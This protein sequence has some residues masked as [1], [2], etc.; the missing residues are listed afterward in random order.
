MDIKELQ[1][2]RLS[3]AVKFHDS[4]N[5]V[6]WDNNEH[7]RPEV[8]AALLKIAE[9]FKEFLGVSDFDL[10]DIT[11]S[12]SNAA[13]SY[14][15]HSDVDL[16]L[17]VDLPKADLSDVYR[18]LFD[19]KKYQYNDQ[20]NY[21]IGDADV[22][23]YVQNANQPHVSQGIYSIL[24]NDWLRVPNKRQPEIHDISVRSKYQ[25]LGHRIEA[26]IASKD[27]AQMAAIADKVKQLRKSGLA[28]TGEFGP[29]NLAFKLLRNNGLL[30]AL[31]Q[32]RRA[33]KDREFSI[34][35]RK[36]RRTKWGQ[37]GGLWFPGFDMYGSTNGD[38]AEGSESQQSVKESVEP[39]IDK[40][41][42]KPILR[43][44][45]DS[46]VKY[47]KLDHAP[48]LVVKTDPAWQ[49]RNGSFGRFDHDTNTI[50]LAT[51]N[52]HILDILRTMAH[53]ITHARQNE[54][55]GNMPVD[56]GVTGSPFEDHA[57]A[58]A[59]RIMR[60][61]ADS[62]PEYF[63]GI[64]LTAEDYD[65]NGPPPGPEFKPTMPAGTVKVDV[66]DVY[67]WYKLG[68]HV[69]NLKGLG[70]HDFGKGPPSTIM[71]FGSEQEEHKYIQDLEK[72]GL[73]T[74]DI[75]PVDP[76]QPPG[77]KRQKTDPTYNVN[78]A[79]G[80]IP[81]NDKEAK[82]PRYSMAITQDIK[83]GE[84]KRQAAKMG[85][86]TSIAGLPPIAKTNG[87][88]EAIDVSRYQPG[89]LIDLTNN[90]S[91]YTALVG[92]IDSVSP[93]NMVKMT[94]VA[95]DPKPG[96]KA[97]LTTGTKLNIHANYLKRSPVS[98][99]T[100]AEIDRR[101][102]LKGITGTAAG[103][104]GLLG[105]P[106]DVAQAR[107]PQVKRPASPREWLEYIAKASGIVGDEFKA[108]L[109]QVAHETLNF[110]KMEE[111][112][113]ARYFQKKYDIT[114]NPAKAKKLGNTKPGDG[115]RY[116]G[117]GLIQLT[118]KDNYQKAG[119]YLYKKGVLKSP[120]ELV[121][122]PALA[123]QPDLAARIAIWY[124]QKRVAPKVQ[125]FTNVQATTKPINPGMKHLKQRQEKFRQ[126]QAGTLEEL[127]QRLAEGLNEFKQVIAEVK[128]SPIEYRKWLKSPEAQG[129]MAGFEAELIF[130]DAQGGALKDEDDDE[131]ELQA[132]YSNNPRTRSISNIVDFYENDDWG[133]GLSPRRR[134]RLIEDLNEAWIEW[135]DE[136]L[137][138]QWSGE[139]NDY[140]RTWILENIDE[141]E[142]LAALGMSTA[143]DRDAEV[144]NAKLDELVDNELLNDGEYATQARQ[145]FNDEYRDDY[146]ESTWLDENY[147]YMDD[148]EGGF[149]VDW[150][151]LQD[152][153]GG[154][155]DRGSRE[156][157]DIARSLR[158]VVEMPVKSSTGYH[159]VT[160]QPGVWIV[161]KDS[162]LEP[163]EYDETGLEIV[164]PPMPLPEALQALKAVY[165]WAKDGDGDAY[166]NESTGL[167][168]NISIPYVGGE[169]DYVKLI[170]FMGDQY[171]LDKFDR[172]GTHYC[173]SAMSKLVDRIQPVARKQ[174][175]TE[176][177]SNIVDPA[178]AIELIKK[179]LIELAG[180]YIRDGVGLDKYTSAHVK[181]G[182][183]GRANYIE[184][185]SPGG[186]YLKQDINTL[187][188][189]MTRFARALQIAGNPAAERQEYAKKL[190][191]FLTAPAATETVQGPKGGRTQTV[192]RS[193]KDAATDIF[194]KY[195]SK[196]MADFMAGNINKEQVDNAWEKVKL[197]WS[198][199]M[200]R[201]ASDTAN[202]I[203]WQV[204]SPDG[205]TVTTIK[206]KTQQDAMDQLDDIPYSIMRPWTAKDLK[207]KPQ[208]SV[209]N[210]K[211]PVRSKKAIDFA[212]KISS[213]P[214]TWQVG[215][216]GY[217]MY[218]QVEATT[219]QEAI[220]KAVADGGPEW[221]RANRLG[222]ITAEPLSV[223]KAADNAGDQS[224]VNNRVQRA[225]DQLYDWQVYLT[226]GLLL[227]YYF[228]RQEAVAAAQE[229]ANAI[230]TM[231][232]VSPRGSGGIGAISVQPQS[233]ASSASSSSSEGDQYEIFNTRTGEVVE[234]F[235]ASNS[236]EA[237]ELLDAYRLMGPH[238]LS[239]EEASGTFLLR[240]VRPQ[241]GEFTGTWQIRDANNQVIHSFTGVGNVQSDANRWAINWLRQNPQHL[242][243]GVT[244]TPLMR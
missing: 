206:A 144:F 98:E 27:S 121:L 3:D 224:S 190:A 39:N 43:K 18:E 124:W 53:E 225:A 220:A 210:R 95:V 76:K 178:G 194:T 74:T 20:H 167:H 40:K 103:I 242:R 109:A 151:I 67:D 185:R 181:R 52:R 92:K 87:L 187:T 213:Q 212:K 174:G 26:A 192:Y 57:N 158:H 10:K 189:T 160:R 188:D 147:R 219:E 108:L 65:P 207:V 91:A 235:R 8:R 179:N 19:A 68:Q 244:V 205:E 229:T 230:G 107:P 157:S 59:G 175:I 234:Q 34:T 1:T 73:T 66:S 72:T 133:V 32:A 198:Q 21:T 156:P 9:D 126:A 222:E 165:D 228:S 237:F 120:D 85:F 24:N 226:T 13:Y 99:N 139:S 54:Q 88:S 238:N 25:D 161:E 101:S 214:K 11:I 62:H 172:A 177:K 84:I 243:D 31:S 131:E 241:G 129:I 232:M 221:E 83:P 75:D 216:R 168:M 149:N 153:G 203:T 102:F 63:K 35:E 233:G 2:Y 50:Y 81:V 209:S 164:S 38:S 110:T 128:Q 240:H 171:V 196:P 162:S 191:K 49:Q 173:K 176:Q 136:S 7:L 127:E 47:L 93:K 159:S 78:E 116:K 211:E 96:M 15:P 145:A 106:K 61:W 134:E 60:H 239:R 182:G 197:R 154:Q 123:A 231:V 41:S 80:Y 186:N 70:K 14:T 180:Q 114:G 28:Q 113:S 79:T 138:D 33:V 170:M 94:V 119:Q 227:G 17:V 152:T 130:R 45:Y 150:P 42:L 89:K 44:F 200:E 195:L 82:D 223:K 208:G 199:E 48:K 36:K 51:A 5:P 115:E 23:L 29:E 16:H 135:Q 141:D 155:R 37:Y 166:T 56:A 4:L 97:T 140:V 217:M 77:M 201:R 111:V 137:D 218:Y 117:R 118:G 202:L 55:V 184:F 90:F 204:Y 183:N 12:G 6:L 132:D 69:S 146:D 125:D 163:D 112:G 122:N 236:D 143:E 71:A 148:I 169:V 215:R 100:V 58:M 104:G 64:D 46:C 22:E 30:D 193:E 86:K 105:G 142:L